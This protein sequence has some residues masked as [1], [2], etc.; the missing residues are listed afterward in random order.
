MR[1]P[2]N[3]HPEQGASEYQKTRILTSGRIQSH[4][5]LCER[6]I[7]LMKDT[8]RFDAERQRQA[9]NILSQLQRGLNIKQGPAKEFYKAL[10]VIWDV[11][12]TGSL[13][14]LQRATGLLE[15]YHQTLR[16]VAGLDQAQ[17]QSI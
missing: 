16:V 11:I 7:N 4:I 3:H 17:K 9:R 5:M 6:A 15:D 2:M 10:A 13:A 14:E 8:A 12:G 1:M